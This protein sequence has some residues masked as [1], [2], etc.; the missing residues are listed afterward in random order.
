MSLLLGCLI[1]WVA[2]GCEDTGPEPIDIPDPTDTMPVEPTWKVLINEIKGNYLGTCY[3]HNLT[4]H[5]YLDTLYNVTFTIDSLE[6][7]EYNG[8]INYKLTDEN[9]FFVFYI[10]EAEFVQD[11][12]EM[13]ALGGSQA[14]VKRMKFIRSQRF[15]YIDREVWSGI[16][17]MITECYCTKQ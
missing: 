12:V 1:I 5:E 17:F 7:H 11:T 3:I 10:P 4:S 9:G 14:Y 8:I 2:Y 13:F 6:R 16:G 15:L